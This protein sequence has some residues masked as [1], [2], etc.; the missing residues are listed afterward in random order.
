MQWYLNRTDDAPLT[1]RGVGPRTMQPAQIGLRSGDRGSFRGFPD[2]W[3]V[4]PLAIL[5]YRPPE[6]DAVAHR[7]LMPVTGTGSQVSY[8]GRAVR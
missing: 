6:S 4:A 8:S 5:R 2:D 7:T 3:G 1:C